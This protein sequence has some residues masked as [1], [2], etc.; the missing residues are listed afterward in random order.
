MRY[1]IHLANGRTMFA[2]GNDVL[3]VAGDRTRLK[4]FDIRVD[5]LTVRENPVFIPVPG[6][7]AD[8]PAV[9]VG[10]VSIERDDQ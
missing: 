9:K 8:F 1:R 4:T 3:C 7:R 10:I 6:R 5:L 2:A